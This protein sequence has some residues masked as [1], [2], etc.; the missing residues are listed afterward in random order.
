VLRLGAAAA[1]P[2]E[3]ARAAGADGGVGP[4]VLFA[5]AAASDFF[6]GRLARLSRATAHG[7]LLDTVADVAFVLG[8]TG[9]GAA[10][11]LVPWAAPAAIAAAVAA[12]ALA[13]LRRST[14]E[15][16]WRLARSRVGHAAGVV[17]YGLAGLVAGAVA[18]PHPGWIPALGL[19]SVVVVAVNAAAVLARW[20]PA[21]QLAHGPAQEEEPDARIQ[22]HERQV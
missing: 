9:G 8:A 10:L 2:H 19:A 15:G 21:R 17:N 16:A 12:Y 3:L 18:L 5:A 11:G 4:L 13:S 20:L 6:D 22:H 1:M 7:A 14:R